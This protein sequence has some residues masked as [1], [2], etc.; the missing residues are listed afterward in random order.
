MITF[1]KVRFRADIVIWCSLS[2][3]STARSDPIPASLICTSANASVFERATEMREWERGRKRAGGHLLQIR[4]WCPS[5]LGLS[6]CQLINYL[7][8]APRCCCALPVTINLFLF[9]FFKIRFSI[10]HHYLCQ[11]QIN[12]NIN[13]NMHFMDMERHRFILLL[14]LFLIHL[15]G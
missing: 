13:I 8:R 3:Q 1:N 14:L 10:I 6:A 11:C 2:F 7:I 4:P 9:L 15:T 5:C 12:I